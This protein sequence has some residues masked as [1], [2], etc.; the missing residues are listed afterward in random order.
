MTLILLIGNIFKCNAFILCCL[1]VSTTF[2]LKQSVRVEYGDRKNFVYSQ[3]ILPS[4]F[5]ILVLFVLEFT[6]SSLKTE[7]VPHDSTREG[8][9]LSQLVEDIPASQTYYYVVL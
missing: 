4:F 3:S 2:T 1:R 8:R 5:M 9:N 7:Y 6:S